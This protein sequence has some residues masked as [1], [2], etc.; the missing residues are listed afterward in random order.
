MNARD[1]LCRNLD[2]SQ[3]GSGTD[4]SVFKGGS[5]QL[6]SNAHNCWCRGL[7]RNGPRSFPN[8]VRPR[9]RFC[10]VTDSDQA[11]SKVYRSHAIFLLPTSFEGLPLVLIEAAAA[12][13]PIVT[14]ET[15]GMRDMIRHDENGLF[16]PI[17]DPDSLAKAIERLLDEPDTRKR[18]GDAAEKTARN[19]TWARSAEAYFNA[20]VATARS[21]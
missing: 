17:A 5:N 6:R 8:S 4:R 21:R 18:L 2:R 1:S 14:T 10:P 9:I 13:L 3:G 7:G 15:C 16:V 11:L 20:C 12:G 19:Y